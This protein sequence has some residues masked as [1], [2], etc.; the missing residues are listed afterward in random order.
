MKTFQNKEERFL[1]RTDKGL[2]TY[3]VSQFWGF[4]PPPIVSNRHLLT[5]SPPLT[6]D[7]I[8]L[9][10]LMIQT[11]VYKNGRLV[12]IFA[13]YALLSQIRLCRDDALFF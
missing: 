8:Q 9:L 13:K 12:Q 4:P 1:V 6:A 7:I 5:Y 11:Q 10:I 3:Y 2:F